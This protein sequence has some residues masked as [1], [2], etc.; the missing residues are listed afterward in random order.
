LKG[1]CFI[2]SRKF[3]VL[4]ALQ[5]FFSAAL[6]MVRV[7]GHGLQPVR[8]SAKKTAGSKYPPAEPEALRL[9]AP[10]RGLIATG[11]K[12]KQPQQQQRC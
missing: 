10:Q 11:E 3:N 12:Q 4:V 1:R 6:N 8:Q 9:L 5:K 7:Q 2:D